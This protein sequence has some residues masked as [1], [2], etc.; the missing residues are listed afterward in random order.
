VSGWS[1]VDSSARRCIS[2]LSPETVRRAAATQVLIPVGSISD[3]A[4]AEY[5]QIMVRR[6]LTALSDVRSSAVCVGQSP[7]PD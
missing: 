3:G 4:V 1:F 7:C 5:A 6:R 2:L